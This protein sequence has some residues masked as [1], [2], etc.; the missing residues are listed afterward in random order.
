MAKKKFEVEMYSFGEYSEW[1][2]NS[3]SIPKLLDITDVIKAD[4]GTEF[5]Y[6]LKIKKGKGKRIDFRI[7]H[8]AFKGDDG[9]V[10]PPFTGQV[11]I[12][13]NYYEFF[14]G[15]C[16]WAPASDKMGVWTMTTKIDG[17]LVAQKSIRLIGKEP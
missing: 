4:V 16:V 2:R 13:S 17:Q 7:D 11:I 8:P 14:L 15:D 10:M 1:E 12:N 3:K 6:V 9:K 5:G